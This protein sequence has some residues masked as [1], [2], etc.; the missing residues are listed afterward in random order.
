MQN[1]KV[2]ISKEVL[3]PSNSQNF[4]G[5]LNSA[6]F[7]FAGNEFKG[8]GP[9]SWNVSVING[10]EGYLFVTGSVA[11]KLSTQCVRCLE[12][13]SVEIDSEVEGYVKF[14][15]DAKLPEDVGEDECVELED[16][17]YINLATFLEGAIT[18]DLP[19]QPLCNE[20][21]EGLFEYCDKETTEEADVQ[22]PF[23]VLKN[24]DFN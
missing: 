7:N 20:T 16:G 6:T 21:C 22:H 15:P 4:E 8:C 11:G 24:F 10:G 14:K 9:L 13:A 23:E 18:L 5:V 3:S 12:D 19:I 2:Q 1:V 17:K